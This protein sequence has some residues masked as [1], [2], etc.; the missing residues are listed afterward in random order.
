MV[1]DLYGGAKSV[2]IIPLEEVR[3]YIH[4]MR[5]RI[6]PTILIHVRGC[7]VLCQQILQFYIVRFSVFLHPRQCRAAVLPVQA[8]LGECGWVLLAFLTVSLFSDPRVNRP[9]AANFRSNYQNFGE[10][11]CLI[12]G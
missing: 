12:Y 4:F 3:V 11:V 2:R 1:V 10:G 7:N 5:M 8:R 9:I 6:S